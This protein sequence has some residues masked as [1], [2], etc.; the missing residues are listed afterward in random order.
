MRVVRAGSPSTSPCQ[1]NVPVADAMI[2]YRTA[3]IQQVSGTV[4][5]RIAYSYRDLTIDRT[6]SRWGRFQ[7]LTTVSNSGA[8]SDFAELSILKARPIP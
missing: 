6:S 2:R 4:K 7:I 8:S 5:Y 1:S 3:Q